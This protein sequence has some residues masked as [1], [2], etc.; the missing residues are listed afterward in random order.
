[1]TAT[2]TVVERLLLERLMR[3][4]ELVVTVVDGRPGPSFEAARRLEDLGLFAL[5]GCCGASSPT[6][7]SLTIRYGLTAEGVR[8]ARQVLS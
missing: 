8:A 3:A 5:R 1:M 7:R 6:R 2:L 4:R